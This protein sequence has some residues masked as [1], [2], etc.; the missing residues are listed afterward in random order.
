LLILPPA[1]QFSRYLL[2]LSVS[3]HSL[4]MVELYTFAVE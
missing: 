4:E 2:Q 3:D 1:P